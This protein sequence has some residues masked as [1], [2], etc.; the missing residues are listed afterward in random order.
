MEVDGT[1]RDASCMAIE[2]LTL[3]GGAVVQVAAGKIGGIGSLPRTAERAAVVQ[4][5]VT[6]TGGDRR[7]E[8]LSVGDSF[9]LGEETWEVTGVN[10]PNA[11]SWNVA[12]RL[13]SWAGAWGGN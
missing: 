2:D 8:K 7:S 4:L 3:L 5:S 13:V 1:H 9:P 11:T 12:L 6:R 10:H